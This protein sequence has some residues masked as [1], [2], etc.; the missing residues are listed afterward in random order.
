[1]EICISL[2]NRHDIGYISH[3][4]IFMVEISDCKIQFRP[5]GDQ[6]KFVIPSK[7]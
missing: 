1:M 6:V 4:F 3:R 7:L 5:L 2:M